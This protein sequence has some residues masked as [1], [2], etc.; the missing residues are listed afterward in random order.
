MAACSRV[1]IYVASEP[2]SGCSGVKL[3]LSRVPYQ[4]GFQEVHFTGMAMLQ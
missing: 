4:C 3:F 2:K 1:Q